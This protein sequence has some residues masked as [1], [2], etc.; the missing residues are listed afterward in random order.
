MNTNPNKKAFTLAEILITLGLVGIIAA[1]T[2]PTL[3]NNYNN[4][5]YVTKLKKAY[6]EFS[7]AIIQ[8]S[9]D[10][11]CSGDIA[12]TGLF[13]SI[14]D[15]NVF[16]DAVSS[17]FKGVKN[18]R[19]TTKQG[20]MSSLVSTQTDGSLTRSSMDAGPGMYRFVTADGVSFSMQSYAD[21][22]ANCNDKTGN[23]KHHCADLFIDV[24]G[25]QGPNNYGRDIYEFAIVNDN[26]PALYPYGGKKLADWQAFEGCDPPSHTPGVYCAGRIMQEGW[27]MNY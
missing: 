6:T 4:E 26:G 5:Q 14:A 13:P 10:Y 12:C 23:F 1:I 20:C 18:C 22:N 27:K 8:L 21:T 15:Y 2:I 17:Y 16:G 19:S 7:Q 9:N 11:G 3:M 25:L 24:N